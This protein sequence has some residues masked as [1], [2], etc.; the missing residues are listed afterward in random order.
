MTTGRPSDRTTEGLQAQ[1]LELLRDLQRETGMALIITHDL[2]VAAAMADRI[3]VRRLRSLS[4]QPGPHGMRLAALCDHRAVKGIAVEELASGQQLAVDG[5]QVCFVA[6]PL[7]VLGD[8]CDLM[9]DQCGGFGL[10]QVKIRRGGEQ[11][12]EGAG[13]AIALDQRGFVARAPLRADVVGGGEREHSAVPEGGMVA[14]MVVS[15]AAKHV[16]ADP[17]VEFFERVFG[18]GETVADEFGKSCRKRRGHHFIKAQH[19]QGRDHGVPRP[20]ILRVGAIEALD[21]QHVFMGG[22]GHRHGGYV[23]TACGC[24]LH[25]YEFGLHNTVSV[26]SCHKFGDK[27]LRAVINEH[28]WACTAD[29]SAVIE[30][31]V[32]RRGQGYAFFNKGGRF[33]EFG[34]R[35][36]CGKA[37]DILCG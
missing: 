34:K 10:F 15:V 12:G 27:F 20:A 19:G 14:G 25:R 35:G 29:R 24:Q 30:G 6:A 18:I 21:K 2:E 1:I 32:E 37:G 13:T 4:A 8:G 16:E 9:F 31:L 36:L 33:H 22:A 11:G 23:E 3:I 26:V 5:A 28:L 17:P 7:P